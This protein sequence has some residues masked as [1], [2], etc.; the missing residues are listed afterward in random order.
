MNFKIPILSMVLF[1]ART[2]G[3]V[4]PE[5][6]AESKIEKFQPTLVLAE[7]G[8]A[9][10]TL[11]SREVQVWEAKLGWLSAGPCRDAPPA[12]TVRLEPGESLGNTVRRRGPRLGRHGAPTEN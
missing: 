5:K 11:Q 12:S 3:Q 9:K 8:A 2:N 10:G 6:R 4:P 1:C 7:S